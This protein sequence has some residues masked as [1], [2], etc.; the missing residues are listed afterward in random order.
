[1]D[2]AFHERLRHGFREIAAADPQRCV[3]IEASGGVDAVHRT[4]VEAVSSRLGVPLAP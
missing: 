1:L 4:V 2:R 3:L